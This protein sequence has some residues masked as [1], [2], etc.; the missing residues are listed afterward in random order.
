MESLYR[1][2]RILRQVG[3]SPTNQKRVSMRFNLWVQSEIL[4]ERDFRSIRIWSLWF[5]G[6]CIIFPSTDWKNSRK[7]WLQNL[8]K[9]RVWA[10]FYRTLLHIIVKVLYMYVFVCTYVCKISWIF[11][12]SFDRKAALRYSYPSWVILATD[13]PLWIQSMC[14]CMYMYVCRRTFAFSLI[15]VCS[16]ETEMYVCLYSY[17]HTYVHIKFSS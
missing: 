16:F 12:H 15:Y 3:E 13:F 8:A 6:P 17:I 11:S 4:S 10:N 5:L 1:Q 14:V 2:H 9:K 7:V